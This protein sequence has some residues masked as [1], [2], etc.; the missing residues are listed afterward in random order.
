M[1]ED[2]RKETKQNVYSW[3][4]LVEQLVDYCQ[5]MKAG[6]VAETLMDPKVKCGPEWVLDQLFEGDKET[7]TDAV[8]IG[9]YV[10]TGDAWH[11]GS[12]RRRAEIVRRVTRELSAPKRKKKTKGKS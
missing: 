12:A 11:T 4:E 3:D 2:Q 5:D 10:V 6:E 8:R 7:P 9:A 1:R